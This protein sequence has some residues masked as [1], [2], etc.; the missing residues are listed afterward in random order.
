MLLL[1]QWRQAHVEEFPHSLRTSPAPQQMWPLQGPRPRLAA[2]RLTL[3][4]WQQTQDVGE[5]LAARRPGRPGI[6]SRDIPIE[7]RRCPPDASL[8]RKSSPGSSSNLPIASPVSPVQRPS[9]VGSHPVNAYREGRIIMLIGGRQGLPDSSSLTTMW[10]CRRE[11]TDLP[12]QS[13]RG[14]TGELDAAHVCRAGG[15]LCRRWCGSADRHCR[16]ETCS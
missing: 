2:G 6:P 16:R 13:V 3:P 4:Q 8:L 1:R 11:E 14:L 9:S 15:G 7:A 5:R 10:G 12:R